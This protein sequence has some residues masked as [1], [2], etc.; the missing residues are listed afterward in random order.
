MIIE[1][2]GGGNAIAYVYERQK[3]GLLFYMGTNIDQS[4]LRA[5]ISGFTFLQSQV[6]Y[7]VISF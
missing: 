4:S 2:G 3:R 5:Y 6:E 7:L 1:E